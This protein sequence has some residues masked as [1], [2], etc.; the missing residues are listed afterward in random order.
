MANLTHQCVVIAR[1]ADF[2]DWRSRFGGDMRDPTLYLWE[3][4]KEIEEPISTFK[5]ELLD[6]AVNSFLRRARASV[7]DEAAIGD[8]RQFLDRFVSAGD[9]ADASFHLDAKALGDPESRKWAERVLRGLRAY[10]LLAEEAKPPERRH[11]GWEKL[12]AEIYRRLGFDQ[13]EA[14]LGHKPLTHRRLRMI[15]RRMRFNTADF[16]AV[17]HFPTKPED[18]F[19]PFI[20]PRVE[21]LVAANR[22]FLRRMRR[23]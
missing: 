20:L 11:P 21:A 1:L 7:P 8:F 10:S 17:F 2:C 9:F 23:G 13:L 6:D 22:R 5:Q 18:T 4:L 3:K 16:C 14:V 19:T 15:L 12:V